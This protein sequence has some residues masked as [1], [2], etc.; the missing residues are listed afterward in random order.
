VHGDAPDIAPFWRALR[1]RARLVLN[2]HEHVMMRY[3]RRAGITEYIAGTGGTVRYGL[4][5]DSRAAFARSDRIGALRM[6]LAPG[7]AKLEF[8]NVS[9]E[10]LDR[11]R[12]TCR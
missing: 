1:G 8:R 3:R 10:V 4:R 6:V 12:A 2:G 9:G 7:Q 5:P 11:S